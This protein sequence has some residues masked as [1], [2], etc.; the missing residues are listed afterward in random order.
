MVIII[1]SCKP[2]QVQ[3]ITRRN[4]ENWLMFA[5]GALKLALEAQWGLYLLDHISKPDTNF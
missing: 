1:S 3:D 5:W 4:F 2:L